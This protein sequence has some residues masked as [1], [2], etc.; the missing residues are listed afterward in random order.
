MVKNLK[1]M[2]CVVLTSLMLLPSISVFADENPTTDVEI[3]VLA[4]E[5]DI[6]VPLTFACNIN[7]N[8]EEGF[9]Y[10]DNLTVTN[11][12]LSPVSLSIVSFADA[13]TTFEN[14]ILPDG[15]PSGKEWK[16]LGVKE[17]LKYFCLGI[18]ATDAAEWLV[19]D[20]ENPLYVK[21]VV[22]TLEADNVGVLLPSAS[23]K[24]DLESYYGRSFKEAKSF[25][26][27]ITWLAELYEEEDAQSGD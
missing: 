1:K 27:Q 11:N 25:T 18:F 17:S 2:A 13:E 21:N 9:T 7:P 6:T 5:I 15:L 19:C 12:G 14:N 23:I 3:E 24:F 16:K 8:I 22:D 4:T 26:Y 20:C 10:S